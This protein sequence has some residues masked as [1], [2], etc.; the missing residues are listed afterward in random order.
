[1]V[2]QCADMTVRPPARNDHEVGYRRFAV[3][4]YGYDVLGLVVVKRFDN[5]GLQGFTLLRAAFEADRGGRSIIALAFDGQCR[6]SCWIGW[7]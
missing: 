3:K 1:M 2:G 5:E 4:V 7:I 6:S